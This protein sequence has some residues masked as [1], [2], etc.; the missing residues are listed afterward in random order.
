MKRTQNP[1]LK[2]TPYLNGRQLLRI[3][4]LNSF[5]NLVLAQALTHLAILQTALDPVPVLGV[6]NPL[7]QPIGVIPE[8][9][10]LIPLPRQ[11]L[12]G[13]LVSDHKGEDGEAEEKHDQE[14]HHQ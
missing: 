9:I 4:L 14:K 11:N 5:A 1:D 13:T 10:L 7:L 12:S 2:Q 3:K 6:V 8:P